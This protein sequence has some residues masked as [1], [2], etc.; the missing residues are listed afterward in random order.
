MCG[1]DCAWHHAIVT[2]SNVL[3]TL[4]T[5]KINDPTVPTGLCSTHITHIPS[6]SSWKT[7]VVPKGQIGRIVELFV[8]VL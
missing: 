3:P 6:V 1:Q 2:G 8:L 4:L 5:E 7:Q